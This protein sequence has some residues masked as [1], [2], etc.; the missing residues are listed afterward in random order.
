MP[1]KS[2]S[3]KSSIKSKSFRVIKSKTEHR[4]DVAAKKA[5]K[6]SGAER[7]LMASG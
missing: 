2:T 3:L 5:G 7:L 6:A 4:E 1:P